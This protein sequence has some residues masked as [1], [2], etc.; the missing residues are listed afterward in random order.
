MQLT[1]SFQTFASRYERGALKAIIPSGSAL[2][3]SFR[4]LSF[5]EP[6]QGARTSRAPSDYDNRAPLL[7]LTI[8]NLLLL[9]ELLVDAEGVLACGLKM[10]NSLIRY[11]GD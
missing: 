11:K 3:P 7:S 6:S 1:S 5:Q 2:P 8:N 4:L 9:R 10:E